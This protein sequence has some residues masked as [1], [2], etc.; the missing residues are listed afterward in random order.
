VCVCVCVF[1]C[2]CVCVGERKFVCV[3]IVPCQESNDD[4][5]GSCLATVDECQRV[6]MCVSE[7]ESVFE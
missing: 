5:N 1:V 4:Q 2:V 6:S 7:R 3:Q